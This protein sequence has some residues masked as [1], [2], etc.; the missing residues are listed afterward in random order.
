[1]KFISIFLINNRDDLQF[2][3]SWDPTYLLPF[4]FFLFLPGLNLPTTCFIPGPSYRFENVPN[5]SRTQ[6]APTKMFDKHCNYS[7]HCTL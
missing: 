5:L 3:F 4:I 2:F 1:M 7:V 6:L